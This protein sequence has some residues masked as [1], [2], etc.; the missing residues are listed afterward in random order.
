MCPRH[1]TRRLPSGR[2]IHLASMLC[3]WALVAICPLTVVA[4]E[5]AEA[6]RALAFFTTLPADD[7]AA[8][9]RSRRPSPVS[10]DDRNRAIA[11]LPRDGVLQPRA[12][13][14]V[15]LAPLTEVLAF[16]DRS[17]VDVE[18]IDVDQAFVGLHARAIV[19]ISRSAL[20]LVSAAELQALVAHEI[21]HDYFWDE[22]Q[23]AHQRYDKQVLRDVELKCDGIATLT[24]VELGIDPRVMTSAVRKLTRYNEKLGATA[25]FRTYSSPSDRERFVLA[26]LALRAQARSSR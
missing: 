18:I 21:G 20:R 24:L 6:A 5:P 12:D 1:D 14:R 3:G 8:A 13:E 25:N 22:Y 10:L 11:H 16:H 26:V 23:R 15:K 19:L 7:I 2:R 4:R 17:V 9:L